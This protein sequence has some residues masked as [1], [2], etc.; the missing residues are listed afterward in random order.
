MLFILYF[1]AKVQYLIVLRV[2]SVFRPYNIAHNWFLFFIQTLDYPN[3]C[4]M[5]MIRMSSSVCRIGLI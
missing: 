1:K 2:K 5:E 3:I 4:N